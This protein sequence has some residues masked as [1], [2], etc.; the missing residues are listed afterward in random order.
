[1]ATSEICVIV[2]LEKIREKFGISKE[3][4][5]FIA[6]DNAGVDNLAVDILNATFK[7]KAELISP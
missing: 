7:W 2:W 1:M 3:D 5:M 6:A 4:I